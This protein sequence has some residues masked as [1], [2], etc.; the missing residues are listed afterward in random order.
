MDSK[1]IILGQVTL[2]G[3]SRKITKFN[4]WLQSRPIPYAYLGAWSRKFYEWNWFGIIDEYKIDCK[5]IAAGNYDWN[6]TMC[7]LE[8]SPVQNC[9]TRIKYELV[10]HHV[11]GRVTKDET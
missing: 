11:E 1:R 7:T 5:K 3:S 10:L 6:K 4:E 8:L 2:R 9:K